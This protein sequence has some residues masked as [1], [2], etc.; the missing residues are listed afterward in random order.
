MELCQGRVRWGLGKGCAP[1]GSGHGAAPQG[2]G[3]GSELRE[4]RDTTVCSLGSPMWSQELDSVILLGLFQPWPGCASS[5]CFLPRS[6][7]TGTKATTR[8]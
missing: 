4:H 7:T 2:S 1:E 5:C 8:P 3:Q 6:A